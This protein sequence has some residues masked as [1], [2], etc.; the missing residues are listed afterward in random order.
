MKND[1]S[2]VGMPGGP[3]RRRLRLSRWQIMSQKAVHL[4]IG[5]LLTDEEL[6]GRFLQDPVELLTA[7]RDQGFELTPG[8]IQALVQTDR[9]LWTEAAERIHPRLQRCSLRSGF[10]M[11][12][13]S[14]S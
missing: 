11:W 9:D 3:A 4:I 6:R 12:P 14:P 2:S 5:R 7:F 13:A 10:G 8:E 1:H